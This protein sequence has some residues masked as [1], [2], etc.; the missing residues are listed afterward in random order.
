M[1]FPRALFSVFRICPSR[2]RNGGGGANSYC[3]KVYISVLV[4]RM[5]VILLN[6]NGGM[7]TVSSPFILIVLFIAAS[8]LTL[9]FR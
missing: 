3:R 9:S 1:I 4:L 5:Q 2:K 6:S 7:I 8:D